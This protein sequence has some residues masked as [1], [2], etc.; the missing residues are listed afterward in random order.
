VISGDLNLLKFGIG[1]MK[2]NMTCRDF[3]WTKDSNAINKELDSYC[4]LDS[5]FKTEDSKNKFQKDFKDKCAGKNDC[6]LEIDTYLIKDECLDKL[7]H[8]NSKRMLQ[9]KKDCGALQRLTNF[10]KEDWNT[11]SS[12]RR[13]YFAR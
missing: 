8:K 2:H 3:E 7:D 1:S 4:N 9:K 12:V 10:K 11:Y 13:E 6:S 5:A